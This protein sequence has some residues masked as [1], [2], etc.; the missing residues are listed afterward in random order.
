MGE[1]TSAQHPGVTRIVGG[2]E[3]YSILCSSCGD[4]TA[5]TGLCHREHRPHG[6]VG[7]AGQH[8]L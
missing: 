7:A 1:P 3:R 8:F 2:P 6:R 5:V 4:G